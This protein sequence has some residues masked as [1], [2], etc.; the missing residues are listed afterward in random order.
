MFVRISSSSMCCSLGCA[1]QCC[2]VGGMQL[3]K[4]ACTSEKEAS[5]LLLEALNLQLQVLA[6]TFNIKSNEMY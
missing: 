1:T 2:T 5:T 4:N 6:Q 3:D